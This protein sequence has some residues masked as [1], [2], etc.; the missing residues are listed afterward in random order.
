MKITLPYGTSDKTVNIP[1]SFSDVQILAPAVIPVLEDVQTAVRDSINIPAA[2]TP[3]PKLL[4]P[5][6]KVVLI[7]ND[8][9]RKTHSNVFLPYLVDCCIEAGIV[10]KD[11]TIIVA[12]GAHRSQS[13]AEL[14][15]LAGENIYNRVR[16]INHDC[17]DESNLVH[18]GTTSLG[19]RVYLNKIAVNADRVILI[20]SINYHYCAGYSGGRKSIVPGIAGYHTIEFNHRLMLDPNS[21]PGILD[22]NPMHLDMLEGSE[23]LKPDFMLNEIVSDNGK[24][25]ALV[26][27]DYI[28]THL[29][30]CRIV[31]SVFG[32]PLKEKSDLVIASCGGYPKDINLYQTHKALENALMACNPQGTVIL[33][34]ECIDGAGSPELEEEAGRGSTLAELEKKVASYF[35]LGIHKAYKIRRLT[36]Q[37]RTYLVS[38][39]DPSIPTGLGFLTAPSVE[40]ALTQSLRSTS[41]ST[42]S[43]IPYAS[44][45]LPR[46]VAS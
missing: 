29:E 24:I 31:D 43:V 12:N 3:L 32:V 1:D 23:F 5:G 30:G 14:R 33:L 46:E 45:T 25:I 21:Q 39:L 36:Q 38:G 40:E 37:R 7:I 27:G 19:N 15:D 26:S 11:I 35:Q 34:S 6:E 10:E 13:A 16:V 8:I 41:V 44:I 9:T 42:V 17:R 20:G 2:G 18:V 22:Q 28:K 4:K